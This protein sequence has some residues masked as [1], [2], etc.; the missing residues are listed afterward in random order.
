MAS[1]W[2]WPI[3]E[4]KDIY[5]KTYGQLQLN[6]ELDEYKKEKS[7][8]SG[9]RSTKKASSTTYHQLTR[10]MNTVL[11]FAQLNPIVNITNTNLTKFEIGL[12]ILTF[13]L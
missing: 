9:C 7:L 1:G 12:I 13:D 10:G 6:M 3:P 2:S 8:V 5:T 4:Q 11:N